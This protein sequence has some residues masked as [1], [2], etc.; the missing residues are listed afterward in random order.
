MAKPAP[1]QSEREEREP[2][3]YEIGYLLSPVIR[4][5]DIEAKSQTL[6]ALVT[7]LGGTIISDGA[8]EYIDLAYTMIKVIDNK[9]VRF[10]QAYFGWVKF[11]L[12]PAKTEELK[13][14]FDREIS[15]IR[16][17]FISTVRENTVLSKKPLSKILRREDRVSSEVAVE[18]SGEVTPEGIAPEAVAAEVA[19]ASG[20]TPVVATPEPEITEEAN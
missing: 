5:E 4:A 18:E 14:L 6:H 19:E 9:K 2:R 8:P 17:L 20:E 11:E 13:E 15:I 7:S 3:I 16:Y 10:D 12:N 1:I